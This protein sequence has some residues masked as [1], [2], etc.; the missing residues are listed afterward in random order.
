[1]RFIP[2]QVWLKNLYGP[3]IRNAFETA[4]I[5]SNSQTLEP[6]PKKTPPALQ[7]ASASMRR[8]A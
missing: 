5:D 4:F 7:A 3:I 8:D 1:M 2:F 6:A